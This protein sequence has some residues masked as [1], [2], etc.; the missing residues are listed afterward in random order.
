MRIQHKQVS[1]TSE[2][3]NL[4]D[5]QLFINFVRM[6]D[7]K[8]IKRN[9]EMFSIFIYGHNNGSGL[10]PSDGNFPLTSDKRETDCES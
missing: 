4:F 3:E 8:G 2:I 6:C 1:Q 9:S 10:S 7:G 5:L